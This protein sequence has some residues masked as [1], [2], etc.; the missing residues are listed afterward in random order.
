MDK[1]AFENKVLFGKK[2]KYGIN[3]NL[4]C[5]IGLRNCAYL[6]KETKPD[7]INLRNPTDFEYKYI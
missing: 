5:D 1:E 4:D 7:T 3:S 6:E 2:P